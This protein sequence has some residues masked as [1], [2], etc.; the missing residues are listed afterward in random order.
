M[1]YCLGMQS[2]AAVV[3]V[4][5]FKL[6][7][8]CVAHGGLVASTLHASVGWLQDSAGASRSRG[9]AQHTW[10]ACLGIT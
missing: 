9:L 10:R 3:V 4:E 1:C 6:A 5:G 8:R 2:A 7:M